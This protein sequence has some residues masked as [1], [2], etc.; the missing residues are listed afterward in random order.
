MVLDDLLDL[1]LELGVDVALGDLGEE[2]GL[3]LE[4]LTEVGLPL[5]DLLNGDAVEL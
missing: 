2:G 1:G 4:M 3:A 5:G